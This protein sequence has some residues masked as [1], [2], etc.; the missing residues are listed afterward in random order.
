MASYALHSDIFEQ[1]SGKY[2]FNNLLAAAA[3]LVLPEAARLRSS[4]Y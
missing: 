4:S 2:F 1:P 3:C